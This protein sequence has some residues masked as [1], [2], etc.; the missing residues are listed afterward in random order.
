MDVLLC[1]RWRATFSTRGRIAILVRAEIVIS[2]IYRVDAS[3]M[4]HVRL[5]VIRKISGIVQRCTIEVCCSGNG[6]TFLH[7]HAAVRCYEGAIPVQAHCH[8]AIELLK[9]YGHGASKTALRRASYCRVQRHCLQGGGCDDPGSRSL[10]CL[11]K[12]TPS[13]Q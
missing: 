13:A 6:Q 3:S 5:H 7:M 9:W 1:A 8:R 10:F 12:T 11:C 2:P 4:L